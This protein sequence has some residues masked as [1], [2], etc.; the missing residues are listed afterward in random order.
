MT[1][2]SGHLKLAAATL[3]VARFCYRVYVING[4]LLTS[5]TCNW[6]AGGLHHHQELLGIGHGIKI[7]QLADFVV[8]TV[9]VTWSLWVSSSIFL[10]VSLIG[11]MR[12]NEHFSSWSSFI[13]SIDF[14]VRHPTSMDQFDI[15]SCSATVD[16]SRFKNSG[17]PCYIIERL[18]Q[19]TNGTAISVTGTSW[20]G[21]L[22]SQINSVTVP[23]KFEGF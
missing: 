3:G 16:C 13:Q 8:R 9:H 5:C 15:R 6:L 10:S 18:T 1:R 7:D 14:G 19:H 20:N 11:A 22:D 2:L 12:I 4:H 21:S 17:C 23:I